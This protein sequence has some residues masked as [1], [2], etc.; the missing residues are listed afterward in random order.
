MAYQRPWTW[1]EVRDARAGRKVFNRSKS[2]ERTYA[3][4]LKSV[5]EQ[6]AKVLAGSQS[7]GDK[8]SRLKEY[9]ESLDTWARQSAANMVRGVAKKNEQSWREAAARWGIDLRGMLKADISQAVQ[10]RIEENV[11]LIKSIPDQAAGKVAKLAEET[12]LSGGRVKALTEKIAA[13][14]EVARNRARIIALTEVSKA[15]TA[16]T[17][18]RAESAGSE[19]Y[20]WRTAR[21]GQTRPSHRA[22]EGRFVK[23]SEPPTLDGMTGHAGEVPNCRCYPEPG[24]P[25]S[26]GQAGKSPIPTRAEERESGQHELRSQWERTGLNPVVPHAPGK[27]LPNVKHANFA[28]DKLTAYSMDPAHPR[29]KDKAAAWKAA[30]DMDKR[31]AE[32]VQ[33]QIMDQL[34]RVAATP[35]DVDQ[36]GERFSVTVRVVGE[37]GRAVDVMVAWIY[38]RDTKNGQLATKPR[39]TNCYV[40]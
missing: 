40:K 4:Q 22:M 10:E 36:Y 14:G 37:N 8:Q 39:L 31:H 32:D 19:G 26:T 2:A 11:K 28:L 18:A 12:L 15:G 21:D 25:D 17:R 5:A 7:A 3:K 9:A 38:D 33:R 24:V 27:P 1:Q 13:Q 29:G 23:W 30:L 16:L 6:V 35:R 20:I 34:S